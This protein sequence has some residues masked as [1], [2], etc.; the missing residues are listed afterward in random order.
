MIATF[1]WYI[2]HG[3][4]NRAVRRLRRIREPRYAIA[5][6]VGVLYLWSIFFNPARS[7]NAMGSFAL[8]GTAHLFYALGLTVLAASWWL[9]GFEKLPIQYTPAEVQFLFPAP[10][11]RRQLVELKILQAQLP[12]LLSCVLWLVILG[13]G[14]GSILLRCIALWVLFTALY[15]HRMSAWLVRTSLAEH[16]AAGARR[17]FITVLIVGTATV[18][19]AWSLI[20]GLPALRAAFATH[21][22]FRI[23]SAALHLPVIAV[24]SYPF[25]LLLAPVF[26]P[27][28]TAWLGAIWPAALIMLVHVPWVLH[29]DAAFEEAAA[30][31]S[32]R[33]AARLAMIRS[34][35]TVIRPARPGRTRFHLPLGASGIPGVAI[36]WKNALAL[37]RTLTVQTI[38]SFIIAATALLVGVFSLNSGRDAAA[39]IATGAAIIAGVLALMGPLWVRND[40]RLDLQSLEFLRTLP[41]GG[42]QFVRAEIAASVCVI[43]GLQYVL[44]AIAV[45]AASFSTYPWFDLSD[46]AALVLTLLLTLPAVNLLSVLVQNTLALLVPGWVQLGITRRGGVEA[47]GQGIVSVFGSVL[48]LLL[49]LLVPLLA[50]T[51]AS[52]L[53]RFQRYGLWTLLPGAIMVAATA[54]AEAWGITVWL[55][56]RFERLEPSEIT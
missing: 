32:A 6:I 13:R 47:M 24:L 38:I 53:L 52:A 27:T 3:F 23:L 30:E 49:L 51:V 15:L 26:A 39:M 2:A 45:V 5:L 21:A 44:L 17:G 25:R 9:V 42:A 14:S 35:G 29:T 4:R 46:R 50:G 16:G 37:V 11:L 48:A 56:H 18:A 19:A 8:N 41:L 36:V 7:H 55:G 31:A 54:L 10:V 40:L 1:T 22:P 33:R 28:T 20:H 34:R 12:V 43:T